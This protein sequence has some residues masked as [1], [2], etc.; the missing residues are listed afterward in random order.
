MC[1]S[2]QVC[3][4]CEK[5]CEVVTINE[6]I[7]LHE[8]WGAVSVHND[9]VE[10]SECCHSEAVYDGAQALEVLGDAHTQTDLFTKDFI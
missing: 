5:V 2:I 4:D 3:G 10:V 1:D 7:G 6:G 8:F 9:F